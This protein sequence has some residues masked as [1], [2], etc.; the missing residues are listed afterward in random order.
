MSEIKRGEIYYAC[1]APAVGSEQE[2]SR[3]VLIVQNNKGNAHS[4]TV[5]VIPLTSAF[6]NNM[7]THIPVGKNC[8]L[9]V[10]STALAEQIQTI[11]KQ[12]LGDRIGQLNRRVMRKIDK[13]LM[14][15]LS[16]K[17]GGNKNE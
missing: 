14:V 8:G 11:D 17:T 7:P 3:P 4:P 16:I 5:I 6:K 15:S 10:N 12:R 1:L 2:G 13:G 9:E